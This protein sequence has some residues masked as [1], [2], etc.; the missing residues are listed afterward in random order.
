MNWKWK[1]A[2]LIGLVGV[3]YLAY[4]QVREKRHANG[5]GNGDTEETFEGEVYFG[6]PKITPASPDKVGGL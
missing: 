1:T 2:I 5:N 6:V 3:A 4:V